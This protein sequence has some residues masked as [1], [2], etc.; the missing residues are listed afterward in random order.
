MGSWG[1]KACRQFLHPSQSMEE[2]F[3]NAF[4]NS[5]QCPFFGW[6]LSCLCSFW[7]LTLWEKSLFLSNSFSNSFSSASSSFFVTRLFFW[8]CSWVWVSDDL[9]GEDAYEHEDRTSLGDINSWVFSRRGSIQKAKIHF[10]EFRSWP[11]RR[12]FH[13]WGQNLWDLGV[14][15]PSRRGGWLPFRCAKPKRNFFHI[16][17]DKM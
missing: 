2:P 8:G 5:I 4:R 16:N 10:L 17:M 15:F 3:L 7:K 13:R 14:T 9:S 11:K 12:N 1:A 6:M